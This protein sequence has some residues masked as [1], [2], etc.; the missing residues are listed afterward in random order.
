[1]AFFILRNKQIFVFDLELK[2]YKFF[3]QKPETIAWLEPI[4]AE[5]KA[6]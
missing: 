5:K 2:Q 1:M 6:A 4:E 3:A